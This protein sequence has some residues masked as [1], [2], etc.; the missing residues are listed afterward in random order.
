MMDQNRSVVIIDD[1]G[2]PGHDKDRKGNKVLLGILSILI[3]AI[4]GLTVG[5]VAVVNQKD[6]IAMSPEDNSSSAGTAGSLS[7]ENS[8]DTSQEVLD[9]LSLT[10]EFNLAIS[11]LSTTDSQSYLD[12]K[13]Q[14]Y[15]DSPRMQYRL[16]LMKAWVYVND[17]Q[18]ENGLEVIADTDEETL[19]DRQ[20]LDY[21]DLMVRVYEELGDEEKVADYGAKW[22]AIY[23]DIFGTDGETGEL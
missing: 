1:V 14:E 11:S 21:Y 8:S 9:E 2:T 17:D 22:R 19:D 23:A 16:K 5:V 20:K 18:V 13:M 4:I 3:V 15:A 6:K 7:S 10:S 12:A